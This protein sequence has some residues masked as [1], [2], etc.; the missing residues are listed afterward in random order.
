[1]ADGEFAFE[2][3]TT[4]AAV[5]PR[6]RWDRAGQKVSALAPE[7]VPLFTVGEIQDTDGFL[8]LTALP[9]QTTTAQWVVPLALLSVNVPNLQE[10]AGDQQSIAV[11]SSS[12]LMQVRQPS[13]FIVAPAAGTSEERIAA[14][15]KC[16]MPE[17]AGEGVGLHGGTRSNEL[18]FF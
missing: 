10:Y 14:T 2:D 9:G 15:F 4:R 12:G 6:P 18:R 17:R 11:V 16:A 1:M 13:A 8:S 7:F 5:D 3:Q